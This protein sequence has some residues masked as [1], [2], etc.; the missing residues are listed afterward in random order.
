MPTNDRVVQESPWIQ[1]KDESIAYTID[2]TP[3]GGS[4]SSPSVTIWQ[5]STNMS[6]TNL[7]GSATVSSD[8]ITTPLVTSLIAGKRY[9]LKVQWTSGGNTL[10]AYAEIHG[11]T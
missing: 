4:A 5:G 3:W 9:L 8:V 2:T 10:E 1:G 11:G 7:S 6:S